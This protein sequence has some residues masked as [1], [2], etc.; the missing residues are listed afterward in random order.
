MYAQA[1]SKFIGVESLTEMCHMKQIQQGTKSTTMKS[2]RGQ[3]AKLTQQS[4]R[5]EAMND[6]ISVTTQ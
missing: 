3:P 6:A 1:I 5:I 2:R 4:D